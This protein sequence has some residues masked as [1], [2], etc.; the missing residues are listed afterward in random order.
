MTESVKR[1]IRHEHCV[2]C[3]GNNAD[4]GMKECPECHQFTYCEECV[5]CNLHKDVTPGKVKKQP[6]REFLVECTF[7]PKAAGRDFS[8]KTVVKAF[9]LNGA[10]RKGTYELKRQLVPA[11]KQLRGVR[12]TC[13]PLAAKRNV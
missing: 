8:G 11:R 9:S 7:S 12:L 10:I 13:V 1:V 3:G 2:N 6:T 5:F 4:L